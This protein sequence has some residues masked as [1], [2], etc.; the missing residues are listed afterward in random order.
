MEVTADLQTFLKNYASQNNVTTK[1]AAWEIIQKAMHYHEFT[2][3]LPEGFMVIPPAHEVEVIRTP[4]V[5]EAAAANL[6]EAIRETANSDDSA[7]KWDFLKKSKPTQ[8]SID[9]T[10]Y[11]VEN[12]KDLY[13]QV[14]QY[15]MSVDPN[16]IPIRYFLAEPTKDTVEVSGKHLNVFWHM[17]WIVG[18]INRVMG[19]LNKRLTMTYVQKGEN[20]Q[21]HFP[22]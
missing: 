15:A 10:T 2:P 7:G 20:R 3:Y 18:R 1:D 8:F 17:P 19:R 9:N 16:A 13:V 5:R 22:V 14:I 6:N 4:E 11:R 21:F 12:W